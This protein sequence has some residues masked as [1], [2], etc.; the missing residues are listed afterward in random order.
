MHNRDAPLPP[1]PCRPSCVEVRQVCRMTRV[2]ATE[3]KTGPLPSG[4]R[5]Y[6]T[7]VWVSVN[8]GASP[9]KLE[10][11]PPQPI[12]P[13]ERSVCLVGPDG[14][15][16]CAARRPVVGS[17][18]TSRN[19]DWTTCACMRIIGLMVKQKSDPARCRRLTL[20]IFPILRGTADVLRHNARS[21]TSS[22]RQLMAHRTPS[23]ERSKSLTKVVRVQ[24]RPRRFSFIAPGI[25]PRSRS[26][27]FSAAALSC[28]LTRYSARTNRW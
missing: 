10:D 5:P 6:W 26:P 7:F 12:T 27:A 25:G 23:P 3:M 14:F 4:I 16:V 2:P 8:H 17:K 13:F 1:R 28:T 18:V 20:D 21:R 19:P 24:P 9:C 11:S 22:G 15:V